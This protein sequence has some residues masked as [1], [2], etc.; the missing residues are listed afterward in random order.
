MTFLIDTP[1]MSVLSDLH[2]NAHIRVLCVWKAPNLMTS[3]SRDCAMRYVKDYYIIILCTLRLSLHVDT[4]TYCGNCFGYNSGQHERSD[5]WHGKVSLGVWKNDS[6][7]C[8]RISALLCAR[9]D[10]SFFKFRVYGRRIN[11]EASNKK[12]CKMSGL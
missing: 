6:A 5:P 2:I 12:N 9:G 8:C 10:R 1:T 7:V 4:H 11:D 3:V